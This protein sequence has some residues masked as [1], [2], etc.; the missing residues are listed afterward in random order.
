MSTSMPFFAPPSLFDCALSSCPSLALCNPKAASLLANVRANGFDGAPEPPPAGGAV[1]GLCA[2]LGI[3]SP[4]PPPGAN[5]P[6]FLLVFLTACSISS[7][8][9]AVVSESS[10]SLLSV[11]S[12][13]GGEL[14][15]AESR[16]GIS[17]GDCGGVWIL[18]RFSF[19]PIL[20]G[21]TLSPYQLFCPCPRLSGWRKGGSI[22]GVRSTFVSSAV[23]FTL[24]GALR[25]NGLPD[26]LVA[27][28]DH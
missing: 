19:L 27:G 23:S 26:I 9:V 6:E 18:T 11:F 25:R 21:A 22:Q 10:S 20:K 17:S 28:V 12:G 14:R 3:C 2:P 15:P 4:I 7:S 5:D 24:P 13:G 16:R 8:A 1:A